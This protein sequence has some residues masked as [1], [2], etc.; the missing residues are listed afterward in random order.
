MKIDSSTSVFV[1]GGSGG[2]GHFI[3]QIARIRGAKQVIVSASKDDGIQIL[4]DQ[5][6]IKDVINHA[7]ENVVDRVLELTGGQGADVVYDSTY[8]ESSFEKSSKTVKEGGS[9][10]VLGGFA[11]EGS[12][13]AKNVAQRKAKL[14]CADLAHYSLGPDRGPLKTFFQ[15]GFAQGAKWIEEGKLKPYINQIVKLEEAEDA[16]NR[17]K[18]GKGGFG[19]IV[20]KLL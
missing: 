7:K 9:W 1:P 2:V 19:K 11:K 4:K 6:Q 8:L 5:Y 3:V 15:G 18:Q 20:V 13:E 14:F 12:S 17:L 10:I 16:L